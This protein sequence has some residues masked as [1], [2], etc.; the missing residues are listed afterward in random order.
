[1]IFCCTKLSRS[2]QPTRPRRA[3]PGHT[4]LPVTPVC[5]NPRAHEGRDPQS[6]ITC[7]GLLFQ[8][9]RPRRARR[10]ARLAERHRHHCFNPRAHEG[11]DLADLLHLAVV[12]GFNPR[13]HEGR[14]LG[15]LGDRV[16]GQTFQPTRPRRARR[17]ASERTLHTS[18]STHAPTKG[19]TAAFIQVVFFFLV[20]THA[21]TKGATDLD[22]FIEHT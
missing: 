22:S 21:P 7:D 2:F 20:S 11:R 10:A 16:D 9:T 1:M 18:V 4:S 3:R 12:D 19:A 6:S 15:G 13:A 8:P 17:C 14:D 5:F